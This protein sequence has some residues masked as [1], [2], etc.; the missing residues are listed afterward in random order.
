MNRFELVAQGA[1][2][3]LWDWDLTTN[4]MHFSNRW[5]S[6]LG[7]DESTIGNTPE[8]WFKRIH[9]EDL[10]QV[11]YEIRSHLEND[12]NQFSIQHRM[13]DK[14]NMYRWMSCRG[15]ITR[16][17]EGKA[18]RIAGTHSDTDGEKV[19]DDLTGLPNRILLL[20]RLT[21]SIE[22]TRKH[23]S[24]L[25]A[26][27]ILDLELPEYVDDFFE[28]TERNLFLV[29]TA[30]RLETC[31]RAVRTIS[32]P[33]RDYVVARSE[34]GEFII[35]IDGLNDLSESKTIAERL[36]KEIS[37]PLEVSGREVFLSASIGIALSVTGYQTAQEVLR[38]ADI[39]LYRSKSLGK[40]RC[41]VFD[42][43]ILK[44]VKARIELETDLQQALKRQEFSVL[45]Q[46]IISLSTY[47][48]AG[49]EALIRWE[50][51][52]RGTIPP[53]EFIPNAEKTGLIIPLGRWVIHEACR[54]LKALKDNPEVPEDIWISVNLSSVQFK[55]NLLVTDIGNAL[56]TVHDANG[57]V[58]ELTEGGV[59][60]NP[61]AANRILMQ[62]RV[63]G[64]RIALDD[65]G[66]GYSSFAHLCR[67]P[68]D[69]LKIDKSFVK[70][71]ETS[72]DAREIVRS[73]CS[74]A[75]QLGLR[76][77]A[78]GIENQG[79]LDRISSL[80]CEYGQGF[81]FSEPVSKDKV[82]SL[83][84]KEFVS[85]K[86]DTRAGTPKDEGDIKHVPDRFETSI[87][88][89]IKPGLQQKWI[90]KLRGKVR[91]NRLLILI[92]TATIILY[93][94][95][96]MFES[97][98]ASTPNSPAKEIQSPIP[99]TVKPILPPEAPKTSKSKKPLPVY[100]FRVVHDHIIGSCS[101]TLTVT[102]NTLS[103]IS[104]NNRHRFD[105]SYDQIDFSLDGDRLKIK[106]ESK[107]YNFK[108]EKP[109]SED[110]NQS[111][112]QKIFKAI[113]RYRS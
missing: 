93:F 58:L 86:G 96:G 83:L 108:S 109:A 38:D 1:K 59:M 72:K 95:V 23:S 77:I 43:A 84:K 27:L 104:D 87:Y 54:Q 92:G 6:M 105:L 7:G 31:L 34:G 62:L 57:L 21:R 90:E 40:G 89:L 26:V 110:E 98:K 102:H 76:V 61:E 106:T 45:Y 107:P 85:A 17:N 56:A 42:T 36:L 37:S 73:I 49:F 65:F 67:F 9:P 8:E 55:H 82:E 28:P 48:I 29:T 47:Q 112:L 4:R 19:V 103:Y 60:E 80:D 68:L 5:S 12:S 32:R 97:Y 88:P 53:S 24:N 78:E 100:E 35:L 22:T 79:Q 44:S 52:A 14:D 13:L 39:A 71:L 2:D 30:R 10:E 11:Q 91:V 69:Y 25:F 18:I 63:T 74:L 113:S 81:L 66:T 101:G 99:E 70:N 94:T 50:H 20:D 3:G 16:D 51:P 46:P 33:G 15:V 41:E 75:H 111:Q 64:A